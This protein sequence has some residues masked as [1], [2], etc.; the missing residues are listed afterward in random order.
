MFSKLPWK[1]AIPHIFPS[2]KVR[3]VLWD[4]VDAGSVPYTVQAIS[5]RAAL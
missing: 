4:E 5:V 1:K 3:A 2:S